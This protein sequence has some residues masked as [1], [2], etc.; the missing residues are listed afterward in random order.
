M[1][2]KS[3]RKKKTLF[4]HFLSLLS[5]RSPWKRIHLHRHQFN[6]SDSIG[7]QRVLALNPNLLSR[8]DVS[9]SDMQRVFDKRSGNPYFVRLRDY[10]SS[11]YYGSIGI[12]NPIQHFIAQFDTTT[13]EL[14][15]PS[16]ECGWFDMPCW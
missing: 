16:A 15:M 2:E 8:L 3:H 7:N 12:G 14:W 13:S 1:K 9:P 10:M 5:C 4:F 6:E 11:S